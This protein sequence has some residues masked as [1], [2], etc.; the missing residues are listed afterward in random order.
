LFVYDPATKTWKGDLANL[1]SG[2]RPIARTFH[3]LTAVE[4]RLY[5]HGGR[6]PNG[7]IEGDIMTLVLFFGGKE[8]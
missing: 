4:N 5:I 1:A 8:V 2:T 6:G 7:G 3:R